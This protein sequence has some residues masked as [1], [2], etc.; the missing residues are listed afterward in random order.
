MP[1]PYVRITRGREMRGLPTCLVEPR[2]RTFET[3]ERRTNRADEKEPMD[4]EGHGVRARE[5]HNAF[6]RVYVSG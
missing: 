3:L 2:S 1:A 5:G 6:R 4:P